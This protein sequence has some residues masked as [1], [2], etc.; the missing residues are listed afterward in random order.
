MLAKELLLRDFVRWL[1]IVFVMVQE[2]DASLLGWKMQE[3]TALFRSSP[4]GCTCLEPERCFGLDVVPIRLNRGDSSV[5]ARRWH[6]Y[7]H[8]AFQES[9]REWAADALGEK[10][11]IS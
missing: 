8:R 10:I 5:I 4:S 2:T 9:G 7:P 11:G 3:A 6:L 1:P